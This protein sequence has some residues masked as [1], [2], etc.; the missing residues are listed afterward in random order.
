MVDWDAL[1]T[2]IQE[3]VR[4]LD[5]VIDANN[6]PLEQIDESLLERAGLPHERVE[7]DRHA[8]HASEDLQNRD[9]RLRASARSGTTRSSTTRTSD[10]NRTS[11]IGQSR[12]CTESER[13][14]NRN[15]FWR[16]ASD[17]ENE[18]AFHERK[19]RAHF[20]IGTSHIGASEHPCFRRRKAWWQR[21]DLDRVLQLRR[22]REV[23]RVNATAAASMTGGRCYGP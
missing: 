13:A 22:F 11:R 12:G 10:A 17:E 3:S 18:R 5:D 8:H 21:E 4:F 23:G 2:T 9:R 15:R 7:F 16:R 6:Y 20:G 1:R 14:T 19:A